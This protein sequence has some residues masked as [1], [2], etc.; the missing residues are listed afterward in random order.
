MERKMHRLR[1]LRLSNEAPASACDSDDE[2]NELTGIIFLQQREARSTGREGKIAFV[3][4]ICDA[5]A[6]LPALL[7]R[8]VA[9]V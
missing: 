2:A 4:G 7:P 6:T 8:R 1:R 9:A 5:R 3:L